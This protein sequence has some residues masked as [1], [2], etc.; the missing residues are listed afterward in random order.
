MDDQINRAAT[1]E[2][3]VPVHKLGAVEGERSFRGMPL[4]FVVA[5][6]AAAAE[7]QHRFQRNGAESLGLLAPLHNL[8]AWLLVTF[9][10]LHVYLVTTG[11]T[12]GEHVTA[13]VTGYRPAD[14]AS[15]PKGA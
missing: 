15:M 5:I 1:A 8:G 10:V 3:A 11:R 4:M 13:M 2:A 7:R 6:G 12:L 9:F 14:D